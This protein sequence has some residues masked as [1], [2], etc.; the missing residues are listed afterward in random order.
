MYKVDNHSYKRQLFGLG[1]NG[2]ARNFLRTIVQVSATT[3][4]FKVSMN[5]AS[6]PQIQAMSTV[7]DTE[8]FLVSDT[9]IFSGAPALTFTK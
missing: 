2:S 9:E 1:M 4:I 8:I 7:S 6:S 3:F 5:F